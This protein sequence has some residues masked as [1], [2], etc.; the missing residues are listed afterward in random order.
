[1]QLAVPNQNACKFLDCGT[2]ER[3]WKERF[4]LTDHRRAKSACSDA[5]GFSRD[6]GV[7]QCLARANPTWPRLTR[8]HVAR[9]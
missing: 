2:M 7:A 1:M 3:A 6:V 9:H 8:G 4:V 5:G